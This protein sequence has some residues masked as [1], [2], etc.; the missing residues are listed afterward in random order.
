MENG[1]QRVM[2]LAVDLS[3]YPFE[4]SIRELEELTE[5]AGGR[6]YATVTQKRSA[7]DS[8]CYMGEGKLMEAKEL[9]E[10]E[11]IELAVFDAELSGSQLRNIE[12]MLDI[13]VI[14]RTMLILDIFAQ[15]AVSS[16]GRLQVELA[17]QKYLLPRL[18][19]LG[20]T[21]SRLGGG[22][23]TRGPGETKLETDRRHIRRRVTALE[24]QLEAV[25]QH[26]ELIRKRR[27]KDGTTIVSIVGYTNVG[28]TTLLSYLT[29]A[30]ILGENKLF[31]TLDPTTRALELPD[32]RNILVVDTVGLVRRLPHHLVEAF[33]ST[34]EV[35]ADSDLIL[36]VCD[37]SSEELDEQQEV[38]L[39][40]L[41]RLKAQSI[42]VLNVLN[43]SDLLTEKPLGIKGDSVFISAK[44]GKGIEELLNKISSML[45]P[46]HTRRSFVL[47]YSDL[48]LAAIL[49]QEGRVFSEEYVEDGLYIDAMI[50]NKVL[51]MFEGFPEKN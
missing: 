1:T 51:Y 6:V 41:S 50:E 34:L 20:N 46:T 48:S 7:P 27:K 40:L 39:N 2:I 42:P 4:T 8:A 12:A 26:R 19:G 18:V 21:L 10:S 11:N 33:H 37:A 22:I 44:T 35:A 47:P 3:E 17:Q 45:K 38:T 23:G 30:G 32:G 43:K 14:D 49:R 13:P 29:D 16:E 9:V 28:K 24:K 31:A 25:S 15:R 5:S 36:N